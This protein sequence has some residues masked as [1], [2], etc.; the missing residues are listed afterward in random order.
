MFA[1]KIK[2]TNFD[3][4]EVEE[5]Y[6]FNLT[7]AELMKLQLSEQGGYEAKIKKIVDSKD[8]KAIVELFD[9]IILD[10]YGIKSED[11]KRF[12]KSKEL[13][14]EFSETAAYEALFFEL[15]TD[16]DK[17]TEFMDKVLPESLVAEMKKQQAAGQL[18]KAN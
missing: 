2:Y 18:P 5:V 14:K 15:A 16:A 11:G 17:A 12:M 8:S 4:I 7:R 13:S 9:H 1:K 6:Y 10:S 3:G